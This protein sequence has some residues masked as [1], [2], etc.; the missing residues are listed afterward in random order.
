MSDNY[1][2]VRFPGGDDLVG[3]LVTVLIDEAHSDYAVG[4][5]ISY[6]L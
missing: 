4:H 1:I 5:P 6:R 2:E 3:R